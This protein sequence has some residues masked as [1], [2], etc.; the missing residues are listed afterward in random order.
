[1]NLEKWNLMDSDKQKLFKDH[2]DGELNPRQARKIIRLCRTDAEFRAALAKE[3]VFSEQ[4]HIALQ[5]LN[6]QEQRSDFAAACV[7]AAITPKA[8]DLQVKRGGPNKKLWAPLALAASLLLA[9]GVYSFLHFSGQGPQNSVARVVTA[10]SGVTIHHNG[11]SAPAKAGDLL[12]PEDR[13]LTGNRQKAVVTHS[14]HGGKFELGENSSFSMNNALLARLEQG[15]VEATFP[16]GVLKKTFVLE[17]PHAKAM[18]V[19]TRLSLTVKKQSSRLDV[20]RGLVGYQSL[21]DKNGKILDVG[22]KEYAVAEPGIRMA[23]LPF[24][25]NYESFSSLRKIYRDEKVVFKDDFEKDSKNWLPIAAM[26]PATGGLNPRFRVLKKG[27]DVP[28]HCVNIIDTVVN[29][30]ESRMLRIQSDE[31]DDLMYGVWSRYSKAPRCYSVEMKLTRSP[32]ATSEDHPFNGVFS[33]YKT[34]SN[35]RSVNRLSQPPY[36]GSIPSNRWVD[37]RFEYVVEPDEDQNLFLD[38]KIFFDGKLDSWLK[39]PGLHQ[40]FGGEILMLAANGGIMLDDVVVRR[41]V[42]QRV[43]PG[44]LALYRFD[45]G[46]GKIIRDVSGIDEPLD[47]VIG[48]QK[49]VNWLPSGLAVKGNAGIHSDSAL[50]IAQAWRRSGELTIELWVRPFIDR[51]D[52]GKISPILTFKSA[53]GAIDYSQVSPPNYTTTPSTPLHYLLT[54]SKDDNRVKARFFQDSKQPSERASGKQK[55]K[56]ESDGSH[57]VNESSLS[58]RVADRALARN[59]LRLILQGKKAAPHAWQGEYH[60]L[61]VYDRALTP[62]EIWRN[63]QAG[64]FEYP[65]MPA[66][67]QQEVKVFFDDFESNL[68]RWITGAARSDHSSLLDSDKSHSR[69]VSGTYGGRKTRCLKLTAPHGSKLVAAARVKDLNLPDNFKIEFDILSIKPS[70]YSFM[71]YDEPSRKVLYN[72]PGVRQRRIENRK[73]Q[74]WETERLEFRRKSVS[75]GVACYDV[76]R[77]LDGKLVQHYLSQVNSDINIYF[78]CMSGAIAIDDVK[79]ILLPTKKE[80][81]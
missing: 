39:T 73:R 10:S 41:M 9:I 80:S 40:D 19:G 78:C 72:D 17:T 56:L 38:T 24:D 33:A 47:M 75:E 11:R 68:D 55:T 32:M 31:S 27:S 76:K 69:I 58:A 57:S 18:V 45:E 77:F 43:D 13:L 42:P 65:E 48:K 61:A 64:P 16:H 46:E 79:V 52:Q 62:W 25:V 23:V 74:E 53:Q 12:Y 34:P 7:D 5:Q 63:Y 49:S 22:K 66:E 71:F 36:S 8:S 70:R 20:Y 21:L 1:M 14:T 59:S 54:L 28:E 2:L 15:R 81:F 29:E 67:T 51:P 35:E 30:R 26:H 50:K 4:I 44:L 60:L 3:S 37:A 6:A